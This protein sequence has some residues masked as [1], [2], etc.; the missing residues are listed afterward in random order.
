MAGLL[1]FLTSQDPNEQA[2]LSLAAGLLAG[3]G[4]W[5]TAVGKSL[6]NTQS[7]ADEMANSAMRRRF[8]QQ[9]SEL[10]Q[11]EAERQQQAM[12]QQAKA[13]ADQEAFR[14]LLMAQGSPQMQASSTAL[15]GGG[16]P[17]VANAAK[18]PPVDPLQSLLYQALSTN[19]IKP[20]EYVTATQKD[21]TPKLVPEGTRVFS[22]DYSKVL[23]DNPKND[24][25][26][27]QKDYEQAVKQGFKGSIL[28]FI[29]A[30]QKAGAAN[31]SI[32]IDTKLGGDLATQIASIAKAGFDA[33]TT[34]QQGAQNADRVI[35]AVDTNNVLAG[36]GATFRLKGLQIGQAFGIGGAD[37]AQTIANTRTAIQG[38]AQST[39]SARAALKGQG[40]I[41]DFESKLL[42]RASSG[43]IDDM[44]ASE[45]RQVAVANKR[46]AAQLVT[47]QKQF[48]DK[49]RKMPSP[50]ISGLSEFFDVNPLDSPVRV[51]NP[52]TGKLE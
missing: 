52:S 31:T 33:A 34:A 37:A 48:V 43:N 25:T 47:Q 50:E 9:E 12:A 23:A 19:Q 49:I 6:L 4:G 2:K 17:T 39:L 40:Q 24:Q 18:I 1:D 21:R 30:K 32:K 11:Q 36:P 45:I 42:E 28:D 14:Q 5:N 35:R 16:G 38:M 7:T 10:R 27:E 51:Y 26:S 22:P 44:T 15:A 3:S 46:L 20:M 29:L 13:Q 8:M 41:S